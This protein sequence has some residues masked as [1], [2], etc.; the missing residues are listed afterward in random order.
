MARALCCLLLAVALLGAPLRADAA[1]T[2]TARGPGAAG[3][4]ALVASVAPTVTG[5]GPV[6]SRTFTVSWPVPDPFPTP[7][8][9][10]Q[11]VRES[12]LLGAGLVSNGS[13]AGTTTDGVPGVT[14]PART[15]TTLT[16]TDVAT[17][18]VGTVRYS[19]TPVYLRW[20][21][22]PSPPSPITV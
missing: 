7:I 21:G 8:T 6:T 10:W 20:V 2:A 15:G 17:V 16:C 3:A 11:V 9:G 22:P 4:T 12:S 13:C 14:Q 19:V 1:W 18:S 5:S